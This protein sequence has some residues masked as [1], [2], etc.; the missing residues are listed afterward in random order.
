M[1][2]KTDDKILCG[3]CGAVISGS[4]KFCPKCGEKNC[5][6]EVDRGAREAESEKRRPYNENVA[7]QLSNPDVGYSFDK[8][9]SSSGLSESNKTFEHT[10]PSNR[11]QSSEAVQKQAPIE[12]SIDEY[13]KLLQEL[14]QVQEEQNGLLEDI[15]GRFT[16][17]GCFISLVVVVLMLEIAW[18]FYEIWN[19]I[20][21]MRVY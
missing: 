18:G 21:H 10:L 20:S 15:R 5:I 14:I 7:L 19:L 2:D 11:N 17:L 16:G 6:G 8:N 4:Y 1:T 12:V 3:K 9:T 13:I